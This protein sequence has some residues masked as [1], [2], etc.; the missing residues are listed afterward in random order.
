V[1]I[2][3]AILRP[4]LSR[5][6]VL[7]RYRLCRKHAGQIIRAY[8]RN[9]PMPEQSAVHCALELADLVG[10]LEKIVRQA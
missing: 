5:D 10:V 1:S 6:E 3:R 4:N 9:Q 2:V 8:K 7:A